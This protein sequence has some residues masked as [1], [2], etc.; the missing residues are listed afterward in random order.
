[1]KNLKE[2]LEISSALGETDDLTVIRQY[3]EQDGMLTQG[4]GLLTSLCK[5]QSNELMRFKMRT[6]ANMTYPTEFY[7]KHYPIET[8]YMLDYLTR[9]IQMD[10]PLSEEDVTWMKTFDLRTA[11]NPM[12][13]DL[14]EAIHT[15]QDP[16]Y[17]PRFFSYNPRGSI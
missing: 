1:M 7:Y 10:V 14:I 12:W 8:A 6:L 2:M 16:D 4:I 15:S 3:F 11:R 9:K 17:K 5:R 13:H